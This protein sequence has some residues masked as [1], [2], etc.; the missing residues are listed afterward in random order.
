MLTWGRLCVLVTP[1]SAISSA[2]SWMNLSAWMLVARRRYPLDA[3]FL[4]E[5]LCQS[6][7]DGPPSSRITA[8][9]VQ[10]R[11]NRST[12]QG[13]SHDH[14]R[15][16]FGLFIDGPAH[17]PAALLTS[18]C[19]ALRIHGANGAVVLPFIERH[20]VGEHHPKNAPSATGRHVL[21]F[22]RA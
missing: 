10:D 21:T 13:I 1:M 9:D 6:G 8:E 19:S 7:D 3:G 16:Q 4:D 20:R 11:K 12:L 15:K 14:I 2:T 18:P 22:P 17:L 5:A